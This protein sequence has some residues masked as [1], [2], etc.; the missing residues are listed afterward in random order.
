MEILIEI[1]LALCL[2]RKAE[3]A[4]PLHRG[5]ARQSGSL[6]KIGAIPDR[7][8]WRLLACADPSWHANASGPPD[9]RLGVFGKV[10][11]WAE[12]ATGTVQD[13]SRLACRCADGT[14]RASRARSMISPR[15]SARPEPVSR[16][17][18][19]CV[20]LGESLPP[21]ARLLNRKHGNGRCSAGAA[22]VAPGDD[23][24]LAG[25]DMEAGLGDAPF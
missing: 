14:P 21:I 2:H 20:S 19:V 6:A 22:P 7:V 12:R 18:A 1:A 23:T 3:S 4:Q 16:R 17:F 11:V 10:V 24:G 13:V 5:K 15:L 25:F 9:A 8:R